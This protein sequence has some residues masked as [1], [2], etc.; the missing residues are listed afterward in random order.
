MKYQ[1]RSQ[2][3]LLRKQQSLRCPHRVTI[4]ILSDALN[5]L[6]VSQLLIKL[7]ILVN[8]LTDTK[9]PVIIVGNYNPKSVIS[10]VRQTL[11]IGEILAKKTDEIVCR[12][13]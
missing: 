6:S 10:I 1:R 12:W 9:C 11:R 3:L 4:K 5:I 2:R 13:V 7:V 8:A